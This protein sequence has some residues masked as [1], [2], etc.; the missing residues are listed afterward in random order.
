MREELTAGR[1]GA[2]A[3]GAVGDLGHRPLM[4]W[5]V[6]RLLRLYYADKVSED[7]FSTPRRHGCALQI[8]SLGSRKPVPTDQRAD[9]ED[10]AGGALRGRRQRCSSGFD[11]DEIWDEATADERG[12]MI[13]DLL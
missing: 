2:G 10:E 12:T 5:K 9:K 1:P 8:A 3:G 11:L 4:R 7:T 13:E 6:E